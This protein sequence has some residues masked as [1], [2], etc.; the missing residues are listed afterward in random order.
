VC[1]LAKRGERD[2]F[3]CDALAWRQLRAAD[4][5]RCG[6]VALEGRVANLLQSPAVLLGSGEI[7]SGEESRRGCD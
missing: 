2:Q 3:L 4:S 7:L 6:R 1:A 5:E